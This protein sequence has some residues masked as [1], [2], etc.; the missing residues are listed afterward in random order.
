MFKELSPW[1]QLPENDWTS[2]IHQGKTKMFETGEIIY[3]LNEKGTYIY[4]VK[5]G[6]IRL[7]Q[8]SHEGKEKAL[9]IMCDGSVIGD[10]TLNEHHFESAI[11]ASPTVVV[12]F[13]RKH[14]LSLLRQDPTLMTQYANTIDKKS[15][16]L[17]L[18]N[19]LVA[20]YDS[21]TR[22]RYALFHLANQFGIPLHSDY[23]KIYMQ[24]TQQELAD[25]IGTS[26]VTVANL[27]NDLIQQGYII[28]DGRYYIIPSVNKI[29]PNE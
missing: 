14:F 2:I 6:R 19:L 3:T 9:I 8:T 13:E 25:L 22:I 20:C 12:E 17:A 24:F 29:L 21:E 5:E 28:K 10:S 18:S 26:R 1:C 16:T 11:T 4:I 7:F 27:V 23:K 15:Q